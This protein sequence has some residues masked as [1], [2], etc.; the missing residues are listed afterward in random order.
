[1][2][3]FELNIPFSVTFGAGSI[4][5]LGEIALKYGSRVMIVT[6]ANELGDTTILD[7]IKNILSDSLINIMLFDEIGFDSTT[8]SSDRL[9]HIAKFSNTDVIIAVG[10]FYVQNIA[11]GAAAVLKNSGEASDYVNGQKCYYKAFPIISI[12]TIIGSFSELSCGM[13]VRDKYDSLIKGTTDEKICI[14]EYII[15]PEL[16]LNIPNK[17]LL[18]SVFS[19]FASGFD[20]YMNTNS[21]DISD[22][23]AKKAMDISIKNIANIATDSKNIEYLGQMGLATLYASLAININ[24]VG[25]LQSIGVGLNTRSNCGVSTAMIII[26]PYLMDYYVASSP[27]RYKYIAKILD[28]KIDTEMSSFELATKSI[29]DVKKKMTEFSLAKG[30]NEVN[31]P[32]ADLKILAGFICNYIGINNSIRDINI[33]NLETI[34][35]QAY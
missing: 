27:D 20:T 8:E 26:L 10:G 13:H 30:L 14:K 15:D 24:G 31:I 12:P 2:S 9:A 25:P 29:V 4:K 21:N 5:K 28:D 35:E 17:Y 7:D 16:Y 1:M 23:F 6:N 18:N 3:V 34:F 33:T 19:V 22:M 11:K 32:R